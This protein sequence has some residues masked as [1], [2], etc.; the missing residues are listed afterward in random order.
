MASQIEPSALLASLSKAALL[1]SP[2]IP[3]T[4]K[5][6]VELSVSFNEKPVVSGNLFRVSQVK[7]APSVSFTPEFHH[8]STTS[9]TLLLVD[10][11]APTPDDPKFAYWR[12]WVVSRIPSSSPSPS[13]GT[14]LTQY[15]APGPKDESKPHRYLYLLYREPEGLK[16]LSKEDV[17]GE[18]FVE[19][20]SFGTK[21]WVE[22]W[23][24]N[25]W[26]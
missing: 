5:P 10:P 23:G 16:E 25:L 19:R 20:R 15:L 12:H 6:S 8:S 3:S 13:N 1:P 11:D 22:K 4:F 14:T 17:G 2:V 26:V 24:W 9:Y 7:D 21:E 18:E